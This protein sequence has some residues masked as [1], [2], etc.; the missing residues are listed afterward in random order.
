MIGFLYLT[1]NQVITM[2]DAVLEASGGSRGIRDAG[3]LESAL[4]AP[5]AAM[6]GME[7]YRTGHEKSAVLLFHLIKNHPFNDGNKRT[8]FMSWVAFCEMNR[9]NM[10]SFEKPMV[11]S[12][13]VSVA[14]GIVNKEQ[15]LELFRKI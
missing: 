13:C 2:H 6:F 5:K 4:D 7:M 3:L 1:V 8:A 9:L 10:A 11:E 15:L 12:L 14:E